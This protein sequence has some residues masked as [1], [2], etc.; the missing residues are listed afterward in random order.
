M[1]NSNNI[2]IVID[3]ITH[4]AKFLKKIN[5]YY[6]QSSYLNIILDISFFIF[7]NCS[8][9]YIVSGLLKV[10]QHNLMLTAS[11]I[12]F[13]PIINFLI[14][15]YGLK[16]KNKYLLQKKN[17]IENE[18]LS[19][20]EVKHLKENSHII[21]EKIRI[22]SNLGIHFISQK[23]IFSP[24]FS[25]TNWIDEE[26]VKYQFKIFGPFYLILFL[27]TVLIGLYI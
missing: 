7:L 19:F 2:S 15:F 9:L 4:N 21:I 8:T 12:I 22:I 3:K 16:K 13:F 11:C 27:K 25:K 18:I 23:G 1:T 26:R 20:I 5:L 6:F 10:F 24:P 17:N 14:F